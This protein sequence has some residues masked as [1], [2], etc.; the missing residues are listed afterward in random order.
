MQ[1]NAHAGTAQLARRVGFWSVVGIGIGVTI[2]SGIFRT[3]AA[4]AT[5]VPDPTLMLAVWVLGGVISLC[6]ALSCAELAGA[7]PYTG[8]VYVYL[9]ESW[10]RLL[11]FLFGWSQL[12]L[13]RASATG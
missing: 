4:I 12:V 1:T 10:G 5:R 2:G 11:A 9:R 6:G 3:P 7:L 8:G 13:I